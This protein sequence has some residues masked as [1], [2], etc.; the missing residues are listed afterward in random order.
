MT[1][2]NITEKDKRLAQRC[3]DC[4]VCKQARARQKGIAFWLVKNVEGGLCPFCKAYEKVYGRK[5]HEPL[6]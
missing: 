5:A 4:P 3:L 1:G 6:A 2:Q